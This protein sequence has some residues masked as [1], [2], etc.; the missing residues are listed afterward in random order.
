MRGATKRQRQILSHLVGVQK[1]TGRSATVAEICA[2]FGFASSNSAHDHLR[3]LER[4]GLV[5]SLGH[6]GWRVTP[7]GLRAIGLR[8]CGMCDGTG[9]LRMGVA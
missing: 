7:D 6:R 2:A 3:A 5:E 4:K 9:M 8:S 1:R